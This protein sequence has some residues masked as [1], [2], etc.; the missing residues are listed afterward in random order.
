M[1]PSVMPSR[2]RVLSSCAL[3]ASSIVSG[4]MRGEEQKP[5]DV[6]LQSD[7]TEEWLMTVTVEHDSD[8]ES[9]NSN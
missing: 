6:L 9:I 2:C 5:V 1:F 3:G 8:G 4:C 7:D